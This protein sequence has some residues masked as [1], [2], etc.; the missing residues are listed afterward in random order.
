MNLKNNI[1][2]TGA[3][4]VLGA[5]LMRIL[6]EETDSS[7]TLL[8]RAANPDEAERRVINLL[9]VICPKDSDHK[10]LRRI[11][12]L[13]GGVEYKNFGLTENIISSASERISE[14]YHCAAVTDF[15]IPLEKARRINLEGTRN[16]LN[17]SGKCARLRKINYISTSFILGN[18]DYM[19]TE[20]DLN[21]HQRFNNSY[22]QSK[23]EAEKLINEYRENGMNISVYRPSIIVGDYATG[24][25]FNFNLFYETLRLFSS[26][27]FETVPVD[28]R[29][30][31]NLV[32][33]DIA[34]RA[35]Y[36]L[37]TNGKE[38][39]TYH[40][41]SPN[42]TVCF[43]IM[44]EAAEYFGYNNPVW[45]SPEDFDMKKL[46]TVQQY[47]LKPFIP[48]FNYKGRFS[49]NYTLNVLEENGF[50]CPLINSEFHTRL[51]QYCAKVD[52]IKRKENI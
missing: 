16:V 36:I 6:L 20:N 26:G 46:T 35:I 18:K 23:Y 32:P 42:N 48:Y 1:F 29:V 44:K 41:L 21:L 52:F 2:I 12:I 50:S 22:E 34:A 49:A 40:I 33:C 13:P 3:T 15:R 4:G 11:K 31:Y 7:L 14:I 30:E 43:N 17:F 28:L 24:Q 27:L 45:V 25:I 9:K 5:N 47:L 8:I 51:F 19:L 38:G 39:K 10:L 37:A